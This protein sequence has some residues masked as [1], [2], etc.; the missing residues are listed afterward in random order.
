LSKLGVK[1]TLEFR[2]PRKRVQLENRFLNGVLI[3]GKECTHCSEWKPLD[4][5]GKDKGKLGD[6]NSRCKICKKEYKRL[7]DENN[8]EHN[9]AYYEEHKEERQEYN[10]QWKLLNSEK[11][12]SVS[13][14]WRDNN[15]DKFVIYDSRRRTRKKELPDNWNTELKEEMWRGFGE[16]C[17]L[18]NISEELTEDHAIPL[19]LGHGGTYN[20]NMYPL[21]GPLNYSKGDSNLFG[22]FEAN[23]QRFEISQSKF[24]SLIEWLAS[25]NALTVREY[26]EFY[27]WCFA[28][29]REVD[30]IK[31]DQRHSIE[32]WREAVGKQFPLP[33]YTET[34]RMNDEVKEAM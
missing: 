28:N 22:W 24:D 25:A 9:K 3:T 21:C 16:S 4:D 19:A 33:A 12:K 5:F 2:K 1:K 11:N 7:W 13:K 32:I 18:T 8:Y 10:R 15:L 6:R 29:P 31:D 20:G 17:A 34:Y 14:I 26:R 30:A 23:R 27:D